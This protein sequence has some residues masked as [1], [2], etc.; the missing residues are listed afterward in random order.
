MF[1]CV[2]AAAAVFGGIAFFKSRRRRWG[3]GWGGDGGCGARHGGH[4]RHRAGARRFFLRGFFERIEATPAQERVILSAA[5]SIQAA[6]SEQA[7]AARG[8][9]G[10]LAQAFDGGKFDRSGI[11]AFFAEQ[12]KAL[13][14]LRSTLTG[15]LAGVHE[16]LEP[17]QRGEV[18]RL[19][20]NFG[21][22][23]GRW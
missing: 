11:D 18:A 1:G 15:K 8:W 6:V 5:E 2:I 22:W 19:I 12:E 20:R 14:E 10:A 17:D 7:E 9:R 23:R 16:S 4:G 3:H 21:G 13:A